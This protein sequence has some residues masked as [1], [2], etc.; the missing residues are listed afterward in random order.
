[1]KV[2]LAHWIK[3]WNPDRVI[4]VGGDGTLKLVAEQLVGSATTIGL[5]PAGSA[6]GMARELGLPIDFTACLEII[7]NGKEQPIDIIQVN[8]KEMCLHL[9]DIGLNAHL[10]KYFEESDHRGKWGYAREVM[11]VLLN[12]KVLK[13]QIKAGNTHIFAEHL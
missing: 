4:A 3:E 2:S 8:G 13:V 10:V 6:N 11:R 5:L 9:S 12:K 1:M 7:T